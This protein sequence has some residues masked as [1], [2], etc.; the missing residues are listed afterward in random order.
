MQ[1]PLLTTCK[2]ILILSILLLSSCQPEVDITY[3]QTV[4]LKNN[5]ELDFKLIYYHRLTTD[6][7]PGQ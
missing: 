7:F 4:V 1:T 6:P 3:T 2:R 5:G